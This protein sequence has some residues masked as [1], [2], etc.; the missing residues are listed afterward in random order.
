MR[1]LHFVKLTNGL[2]KFRIAGGVRSPLPP[3][4]RSPDQA[5]LVARRNDAV[6][7]DIRIVQINYSEVYGYGFSI[8]GPTSPS[9]SRG[10]FVSKIVANSEVS[11]QQRMS[12]GDMLV[13]INDFNV[14]TA[15]TATALK[16]LKDCNHVISVGVVENTKGWARYE[17]RPTIRR[18]DTCMSGLEENAFADQQDSRIDEND[19]LSH[20]VHCRSFGD[21]LSWVTSLADESSKRFE[22]MKQI[23]LKLKPNHALGLT[24]VG[25]CGEPDGEAVIVN[26]LVVGGLAHSDGQIR[27]KDRL[28]QIN[29]ETIAGKSQDDVK[30]IISSGQKGG[31]IKLTVARSVTTVTDEHKFLAVCVPPSL[32]SAYALQRYADLHALGFHTEQLT[33]PNKSGRCD[34]SWI[35]YGLQIVGPRMFEAPGSGVFINRVIEGSL[36]DRC[37]GFQIGDRVV[38]VNGWLVERS[39]SEDLHR[40]VADL[41]EDYFRV[42]V[43]STGCAQRP[44]R[45]V[46][47]PQ[48]ASGANTRFGIDVQAS[49]F[50]LYVTGRA[51]DHGADDAD[52]LPARGDMLASVSGVAVTG[53]T[54]RSALDKLNS[55]ANSISAEVERAPKRF[56]FYVLDG[57]LANHSASSAAVGSPSSHHH[58]G[59]PSPIRDP[60]AALRHLLASV[61]AM[62]INT[63]TD[64]ASSALALAEMVRAAL[65]RDDTSSVGEFLRSETDW[66]G[67]Q[68]EAAET[69]EAL[70]DKLRTYLAR[71]DNSR[72][73]ER[74]SRHSVASPAI[75]SSDMVR[76][77]YS[78]PPHS[79]LCDSPMAPSLEV[80]RSESKTPTSTL[81]GPPDVALSPISPASNRAA[82][83]VQAAPSFNGVGG[84]NEDLSCAAGAAEDGAAD[85][86]LPVSFGQED[87][88]LEA[89][90]DTSELA[91]LAEELHMAAI[92][93]SSVSTPLLLADDFD[94]TLDEEPLPTPPP[95]VAEEPLPATPPPLPVDA[96]ASANAAPPLSRS[97]DADPDV[98]E[99]SITS[100][101]SYIHASMCSTNSEANDFPAHAATMFQV[102]EFPCYVRTMYRHDG[103][104]QEKQLSFD[105]FSVFKI[106]SVVNDDWWFAQDV[107]TGDFGR[108]PSY[109]AAHSIVNGPQIDSIS[110]TQ[111]YHIVVQYS[112]LNLNG[113]LRP[114]RPVVVLGHQANAVCNRL[115]A[116][117]KTLASAHQTDLH[118]VRPTWHTSRQHRDHET[119][120]KE[121]HFV[122]QQMMKDEMKSNKF[123]QVGSYRSALYGLS[124]KGIQ[125]V[126]DQGAVPLIDVSLK[127]VKRLHEFANIH[128]LVI[129]AHDASANA[130]ESLV[131][132]LNQMQETA[133]I[134]H[135]VQ[136]AHM[137][138]TVKQVFQLVNDS[139]DSDYWI[140]DPA[141]DVPP[142]TKAPTTTPPHTG[143]KPGVPITTRPPRKTEVH[144]QD[145]YFVSLPQFA[146]LCKAGKMA[147]WGKNDSGYWYGLLKAVSAKAT[148]RPMLRSRTFAAALDANTIQLPPAV[149]STQAPDAAGKGKPP[150]D[151]SPRTAHTP[152]RTLNDASAVANR[153]A[154]PNGSA[155]PA[156]TPSAYG[157]NKDFQETHSKQQQ[158]QQQNPTS[159]K[160]K[161]ARRRAQQGLASPAEPHVTALKEKIIAKR[162]EHGML[163]TIAE[164]SMTEVDTEPM[165]AGDESMNR[166]SFVEFAMLHTDDYASSESSMCD[167]SLVNRSSFNHS[168]I[169]A[170]TH[171]MIGTPPTVS[172]GQVLN[173]VTLARNHKNSFG[174]TVAGGADFDSSVPDLSMPGIAHAGNI[175]IVS[176]SLGEVRRGDAILCINGRCMVGVTHDE[177]LSMLKNSD[178]SVDLLLLPGGCINDVSLESA[179]S[180]VDASTN[181]ASVDV[182]LDARL[183]VFGVML[184]RAAE[185]GEAKGGFGFSIIGLGDRETLGSSCGIYITR[186]ERGSPADDVGL[187]VGMRVLTISGEDVSASPFDKAASII[188]AA[189][190]TLPMVL[191]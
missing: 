103:V 26:T 47:M 52:G 39:S 191:R 149:A 153:L 35:A 159:L 2:S 33:C 53:K 32:A 23:F 65:E 143:L 108:I 187:A 171:S 48:T 41:T 110:T 3:L 109:Q 86:S 79:T 185:D 186:V 184:R 90:G 145:Y 120:G 89:A 152:P 121:Y 133:H 37:G 50:G 162:T 85:I 63:S 135:V 177:M 57:H 4:V 22:I 42:G 8:K 150:V 137:D 60:T 71:L 123:V 106:V 166:S 154:V 13:S 31:T 19:S 179:S 115:V 83:M 14:T 178:D 80:D 167:N 92:S 43:L 147:K 118:L 183:C 74:H 59:M 99:R 105:V 51:N 54:M 136:S 97:S 67:N 104:A 94:V 141:A 180:D 138:E 112:M 176:S 151:G 55:D 66:S 38:S 70:N 131:H 165:A 7:T 168:Q 127:A 102:T 140:S 114:P 91:P 107:N 101:S 87:T 30:K 111:V 5:N 119:Q 164:D 77:P 125:H 78:T 163:A 61:G 18:V 146:E 9:D 10:I 139:L 96:G 129:Y 58:K 181:D 27:E 190:G 132:E 144:G 29:G 24:I 161:L 84:S 21:P 64:G 82:C 130:A 117:V 76:I 188:T 25:G 157:V 116:L 182:T 88:E 160:V 69:C 155:P 73:S 6:E 98:S 148:P 173:R 44:R 17:K 12:V 11:K 93:E 156:N 81:S 122:T 189:E 172:P 128:P 40:L 15:D 49:H 126:A 16:I 142:E 72:L 169:S 95:P 62:M 170:A 46:E 124:I 100:D 68:F 34:H 28:V 36:A 20:F 1:T 75:R 134:T 175:N 56:Q 113:T 45:T 158:Q 174:L